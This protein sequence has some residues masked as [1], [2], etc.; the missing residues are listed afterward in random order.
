MK[1]CIKIVY[2]NSIFPKELT[3]LKSDAFG[4]VEINSILAPI[5]SLQLLILQM[6]ENPEKYLCYS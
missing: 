3:R 1:F 6:A 5:I 4:A 2:A